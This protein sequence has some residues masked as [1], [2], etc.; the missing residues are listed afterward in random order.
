MSDSERVI[1]LDAFDHNVLIVE[2]T[3]EGNY[4]A[5]LREHVCDGR[6][7]SAID[8]IVSLADHLSNMARRIRKE[9]N[10]YQ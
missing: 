10:E 9:A 8:A 4:R 2:V 6:G 3:L 1:K 7:R 5:S